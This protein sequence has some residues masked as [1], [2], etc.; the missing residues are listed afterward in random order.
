MKKN[1]NPS[2]LNDQRGQHTALSMCSR[3]EWRFM[4]FYRSLTPAELQTAQRIAAPCG[5]E[6]NL[7]DFADVR[8]DEHGV[9]FP[10]EDLE[11]GLE[12]DE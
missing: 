6:K 10:E 12:E 7:I 5:G 1:E 4:T 3:T 8:E 2:Y 11:E 9:A